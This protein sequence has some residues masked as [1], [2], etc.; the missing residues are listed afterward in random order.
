MVGEEQL[1]DQQMKDNYRYLDYF[2]LL[3]KDGVDYP[4]SDIEWV[5]NIEIVKNPGEKPLIVDV[6]AR[7]VVSDTFFDIDSPKLRPW[8]ILENSNHKSRT[9]GKV[10]GANHAYVDGHVSW[11]EFDK[12]TENYT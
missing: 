4:E 12:L 6:A 10:S 11:V 8:G 2:Y 7:D 1:T 3:K 9:E 5:S